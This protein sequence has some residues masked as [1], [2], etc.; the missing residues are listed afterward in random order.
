[1][2][3]DFFFIMQN[4]CCRGLEVIVLGGHDMKN[5]SAKSSANN[6]KSPKK[7]I[8]FG[9]MTTIALTLSLALTILLTLLFYLISRV[10]YGSQYMIVFFMI[11]ALAFSSVF[12]LILARKGVPLLLEFTLRRLV[13]ALD[14]F[15]DP[16]E[17]FETRYP[18][19]EDAL[20]RLYHMFGVQSDN[21]FRLMQDLNA[22]TDE[23]TTNFGKRLD[24]SKYESGYK[25]FAENINGM[26][27]IMVNLLD[28]L[29]VVAAGTD[30]SGRLFFVNCLAEEQG[31]DKAGVFG[32][33]IVELAPSDNSNK[34]HESILHVAST[35]ENV[36]FQTI[37][38]SPD[39]KVLA[40]DYFISPLRDTKGE[41][42]GVFFVNTDASE[43]F[44]TRKITEYLEIQTMNLIKDLQTGLGQGIL[45]VTF[46]PAP[47]DEDTQA[48]Y[49]DFR[50]IASTLS[51]SV[52]FIESYVHEVNDVLDSVAKGNV[53]TSIERSYKGD[54]ESIRNSI[55][56][57]TESLHATIAEI[58]NVSSMVC[59]R[60]DALS[61][62][63]AEISA[64]A[65][66]QAAS[67]QDLVLSI[68]TLNKNIESD[69]SNAKHAAGFSEKS[70]GYASKSNDDM[71]KMLEAMDR[72]KES[73]NGITNLFR[74]M[75]DIAFQTNILA[76][77]A[78]VEAAR[79]GEHGRG[80]AVVAEEVRSLAT[81]S[82]TA[83][84]ESTKLLEDSVNR[85]EEGSSIAAATAETLGKISGN[86][87]EVSGLVSEISKSTTDQLDQITNINSSIKQIADVVENNSLASED[88]ANTAEE[89]NTHAEKLMTLVSYF[90][91]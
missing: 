81:R 27:D 57:I 55:N 86:S 1:M 82:Q 26:L 66:E 84:L 44:K 16:K 17:Q 62:N 28:N 12:L 72:I 54:F 18:F 83:A 50:Q 33:T 58:S 46:E 14:K 75:Q 32:K 60:A 53:K 15:S 7:R 77:N 74:T 13:A 48:S 64:G 51:A 20:G 22:L 69:V 5:Q 3:W 31:F 52:S 37:I 25:I 79:A 19:S 30:V 36:N 39:G 80:F 73:S 78:S 71:K 47:P 90:K 6:N 63:S 56:N 61:Q 41:I 67:L 70:L 45:S 2:V 10:A 68:E 8:L 34:I 91:I 42:K 85:V 76:L 87:S 4:W 59:T 29:P 49:E 38:K 11:G 65:N 35:G 43:M 9:R 40:E 88:T 21:L 89:L 23:I 24:P